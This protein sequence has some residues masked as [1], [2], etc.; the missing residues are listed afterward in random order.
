MQL[1]YQ[2]GLAIAITTSLAIAA[3]L[4]IADIL[5]IA[6]ILAISGRKKT[7]ALLCNIFSKEVVFKQNYIYSKLHTVSVT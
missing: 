4:E 7:K 5:A 2:K 1:Q 6:V 3:I